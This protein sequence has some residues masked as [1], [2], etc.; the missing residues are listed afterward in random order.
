[1]YSESA[2]VALYKYI[3]LK[4]RIGLFFFLNHDLHLPNYEPTN[5]MELLKRHLKIF[6]MSISNKYVPKIYFQQFMHYD[7]FNDFGTIFFKRQ[8]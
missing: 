4:L 2:C 1:M 5:R 6:K 7:R 8:V 3:F